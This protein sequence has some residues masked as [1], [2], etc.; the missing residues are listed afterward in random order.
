MIRALLLFVFA[1]NLAGCQSPSRE[2][3]MKS[4]GYRVDPAIF[5]VEYEKQVGEKLP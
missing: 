2:E 4:E 1:F 3:R 5:R